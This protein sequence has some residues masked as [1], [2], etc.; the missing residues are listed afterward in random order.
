MA[1]VK[2]IEDVIAEQAVRKAATCYSRGVDRSDLEL[3]KSAFHNDAE[4]KYGSYDGHYEEFCKSVIQGQAGMDYTTHT[5]VNE[6]YD[7]DS[8]NNKG[9]GE[10]YVLAFLSMAGS[11]YLVAGRYIDHYECRDGDWRIISRQYIYDWSRT[12]EY[13]GSDPNGL[14]ETLT[15]RGKHTK[16]DLSYDILGE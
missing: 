15:Y 16:D 12:S 9:K 10:I 7:V 3:L 11:E 4:V 14:F 13:S 8:Q 6:Y 1:K 2:N 5:V